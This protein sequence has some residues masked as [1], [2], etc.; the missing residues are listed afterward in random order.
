MSKVKPQ[1]SINDKVVVQQIV[2]KKERAVIGFYKKNYPLVF[3]FI[4]RSLKDQKTAEELTQD[5]FLDFLEEIR[6]FRFQSSVKTFLLTIARNKTVDYIRKKKI[7]KI[8]FSALPSFVIEKASAIFLNDD[9]E[10]RELTERIKSVFKRLPNDYKLILR[11]KYID[12]EKVKKIAEK[13]SLSFKATESLLF[14]AR[15]TFV[16]IFQTLP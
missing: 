9:L 1:I 14:R 5:T 11:L 3:N 12:G 13:L 10:K 2:E 15:K 8:L 4:N 6:D 16:K 7:K